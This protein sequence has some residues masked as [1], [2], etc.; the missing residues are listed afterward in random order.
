MPRPSRADPLFEVEGGGQKWFLQLEGV[1]SG[2]GTPVAG[3]GT[4]VCGQGPETAAVS[5]TWWPSQ[6]AQVR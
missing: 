6:P 3:R 2:D 1:L 4:P 5:A